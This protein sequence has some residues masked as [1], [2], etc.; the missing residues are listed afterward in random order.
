MRLH[1]QF[2]ECST[3]Q[4]VDSL[5]IAPQYLGIEVYGF[6]V[7][8]LLE[9]LERAS[10]RSH[11]PKRKSP[12][13]IR[14]GQCSVRLSCNLVDRDAPIEDQRKRPIEHCGSVERFIVMASGD[15]RPSEQS[16]NHHFD[17]G[18]VRRAGKQIGSFACRGVQ[19][20]RVDCREQLRCA[21]FAISGSCHAA[22]DLR[23]QLRSPM[24][25]NLRIP[26]SSRDK[27]LAS[28]PAV[29]PSFAGRVRVFSADCASWRPERGSR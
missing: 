26:F 16:Q 27:M 4:R 6:D 18:A 3:V 13:Q 9:G 17:L 15:N 23:D 2:A 28:V 25:R 11:E 22:P 21:G 5:R 24:G 8:L 19:E 10:S 12:P 1:L 20:R 14:I 29:F 7:L